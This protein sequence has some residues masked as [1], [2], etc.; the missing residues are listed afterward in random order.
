MLEG[1]SVFYVI[2]KELND[3]EIDLQC[4]NRFF[5]A[6]IHVWEQFWKIQHASTGVNNAVVKAEFS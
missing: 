4:F 3:Q 2:D 5:C 1:L 6:F